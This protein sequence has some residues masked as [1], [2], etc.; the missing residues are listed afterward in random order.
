MQG[1]SDEVP[2]VF[3]HCECFLV[4]QVDLDFTWLHV[5]DQD[6]ILI[7][8]VPF[9]GDTNYTAGL[10]RFQVLQHVACWAVLAFGEEVGAGILQ[11][12]CLILFYCCVRLH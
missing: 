5:V 11:L 9:R 2:E 8:M 10:V 12:G 3:E 4:A 1:V 7:E 6:I